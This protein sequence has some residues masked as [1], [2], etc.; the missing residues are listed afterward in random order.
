MARFKKGESGNIGGRPPGAKNKVNEELRE[1]I[2]SFLSLEFEGMKSSFSRL[3]P[4]DK[5]KFFTDLLPYAIP[6]LQSTSLEM[7]FERLP[8]DQ[9]DAIIEALK[10]EANGNYIEQEAEN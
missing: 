5:L 9:L 7:D 1:A 6:R 3:A 4:K 8:D 10:I 2:S